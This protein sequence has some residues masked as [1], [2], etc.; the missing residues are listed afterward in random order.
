MLIN[1]LLG[2]RNRR[3]K[4]SYDAK[5][6]AIFE[7]G[8]TEIEKLR[9]QYHQELM[10]MQ[11]IHKDE[12]ANLKKQL[13]EKFEKELSVFKENSDSE[14]E[15]IK[16]RATKSVWTVLSA[17]VI[18]VVG[19]LYTLS[20]DL[21]TNVTSVNQSV[22]TLQT[23]LMSA[24]KSVDEAETKI[25]QSVIKGEQAIKSS[26]ESLNQAKS[27]MVNANNELKNSRKVYDARIRKLDEVDGNQ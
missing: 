7:E 22:I 12:V 3:N 18:V 19:F 23:T 16:S 15:K 21:F 1:I 17:I 5:F 25:R 6:E 14:L 27:D 9:D 4:L 8:K 20:N 26:V 11:S 10:L 13:M 24:Q 2:N